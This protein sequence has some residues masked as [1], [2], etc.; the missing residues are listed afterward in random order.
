MGGG[1]AGKPGEFDLV[2]QPNGGKFVQR[3]SSG[4]GNFDCRHL[5]SSRF[6]ARGLGNEVIEHLFV[7]MVNNMANVMAEKEDLISLKKVF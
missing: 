7:V 6:Y 1:G 3:M 5:E 4:A 2:S